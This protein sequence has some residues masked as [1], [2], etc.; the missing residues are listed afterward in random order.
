MPVGS[1]C[2]PIQGVYDA[3]QLHLTWMHFIVLSHLRWDFVYQRPQHLLSRCAQKHKVW[4]WE[5]PVY[6]DGVNPTL[7]VTR[8]SD[9]LHVVVPQLPSGMDEQ[10]NFRAQEQ[11]LSDFMAEQQID[12]FVLWYYTPMARNFTRNLNASAVVYDCMDELSAFRGAPPGLRAAEA[13]T[14]FAS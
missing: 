7:N 3:V 13:E 1:C 14:A 5:E 6:K 9:S 2:V 11:L 4:F 10:E 12:E 8:R